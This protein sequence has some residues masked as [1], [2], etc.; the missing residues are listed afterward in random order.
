MPRLFPQY[1]HRSDRKLKAA[2][3]VARC[4]NRTF[5]RQ[6]GANRSNLPSRLPGS[7]KPAKALVFGDGSNFRS[8]HRRFSAVRPIGKGFAV[9]LPAVEG[10]AR[11]I[12][13]SVDLARHD[14]IVLVQS[15]D[16]LGAQGDGHVTPAEADVGV[17]AFVLGEFTDFLNKGACFPAGAVA[18]RRRANRVSEIVIGQLRYRI[19]AQVLVTLGRPTTAA[20]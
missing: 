2:T 13:R 15:F 8:D 16:F 6:L 11:A 12:E 17:M 3:C 7:L 18:A 10:P 5:R 20:I 14:E 4:Q 1:P 19:E 9:S